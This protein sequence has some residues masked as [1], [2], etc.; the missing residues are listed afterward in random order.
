LIQPE[1]PME[2]QLTTAIKKISEVDKP[3]IGLIQGHGEPGYQELALLNQ[4][5]SI[6]YNV[7]NIRL[8]E[9]GDIAPRL[10]TIMMINPI[11]SIP[12]DH[13]AK[14]DRY[15]VNGG[16]ICIAYN[17][18][19]GDFQ[20]AQGTVLSTGV[21]E[22]LL[23]KGLLVEPSFVIDAR[24]GQIQVQQRQ[25]FF[26]MNSA[27]EFPYFPR[28][29]EFEDMPI[30]QGLEQIIF[31]FASPISYSGDTSSVFEPIVKTSEASG[32]QPVPTF[33]DVQRNWTS[34]DFLYPYQTIGG[35]LTQNNP[36][37]SQSKI[38]VYTDGDLP[39]GSQGRGQT[40]DN[41]SLVSNSID[42][43]SDDTGLIDLRTKGVA[44]RPIKE[45]EEGERTRI[46]WINFLL[47]IVLVMVYGL[48]R[49]QRNRRIRVRRME[50]QY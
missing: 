36:N 13:F 31:Q 37:G 27:V 23:T 28:I 35:L 1:G 4:S 30:T 7:E 42:W 19:Q 43:L 12:A 41:I 38:I 14:V 46:K 40:S 39:M 15:L 45:M 5:L 29:S 3:S 22:W 16:N 18:V 44:T 21:T 24:C 11:D 8:D 34:A 47:P 6:L 50:E 9:E 32:K 26:T 2:Y 49:S 48:Y 17:A 33:F 10:K 25:G 20:S